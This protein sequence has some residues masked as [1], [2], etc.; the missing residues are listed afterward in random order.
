MRAPIAAATLGVVHADGLRS[1]VLP[2]P[3]P[4]GW[5]LVDLGADGA[6]YEA[7][8][9]LVVILSIAHEDD[10]KRWIHLSV[11]RA[12]NVPSWDELVGVRD[13][14]FGPE[15][16]SIQVLAPRTRHVN[17]HPYCLHLWRCLDGDPIPDF[18]RGG[19]SI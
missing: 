3:V 16:L 14:F 18:T 7:I 13:A 12:S 19:N 5:V 10:G 15:T 6:I 2:S 17:I 4:T 1:T 9:G 8:N 11:S